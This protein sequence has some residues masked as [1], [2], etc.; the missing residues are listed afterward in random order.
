MIQF[1]SRSSDTV[2]HVIHVMHV[3]QF[4]SDT[5]TQHALISGPG[6]DP[7]YE[8]LHS[9]LSTHGISTN[10]MRLEAFLVNSRKLDTFSS[11]TFSNV[12]LSG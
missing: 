5:G 4:V 2:I 1:I 10:G 7:G 6:P 12:K 9:S 3:I 8:Q 11:V